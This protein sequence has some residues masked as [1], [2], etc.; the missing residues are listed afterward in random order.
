MATG[1]IV[2][3]PVRWMG[4][5]PMPALRLMKCRGR[6]ACYAARC[7][8]ER[9]PAPYGGLT[10]IAMAFGLNLIHHCL[11][12]FRRPLSDAGAFLPHDFLRTAYFPVFSRF[13]ADI[14]AVGLH[15]PGLA[16]VV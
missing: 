4:T 5:R 16:V 11:G 15:Q 2:M 12:F 6:V 9:C 3:P 14:A 10:F 7:P 13:R 8:A 1:G